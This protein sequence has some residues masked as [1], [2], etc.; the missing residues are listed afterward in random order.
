MVFYYSVKVGIFGI[1][2]TRGAEFF[3]V[4][5]DGIWV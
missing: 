4:F 5:L 2:M 3:L 1:G